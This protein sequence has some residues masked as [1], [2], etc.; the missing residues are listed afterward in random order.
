MAPLWSAVARTRNKRETNTLCR[1]LRSTTAS[2]PPPPVKKENMVI[3]TTPE[4]KNEETN[5][6]SDQIIVFTNNYVRLRHSCGKYNSHHPRENRSEQIKGLRV[7][8]RD[9]DADAS[10]PHFAGSADTPVSLAG[11]NRRTAGRPYTWYLLTF[12][13]KNVSRGA[14][15]CCR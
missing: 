4:G 3:S 5:Q 15:R 10:P 14:N 12:V 9:V 1:E 7:A 2:P 13:K 6:L 11:T 8:H